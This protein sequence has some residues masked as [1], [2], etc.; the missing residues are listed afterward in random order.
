MVLPLPSHDDSSRFDFFEGVRSFNYRKIVSPLVEDY[1]RR[2]TAV[3]GAT[4]RTKEQAG[5]FYTNDPAYLFA[6]ALQRSMQQMAWATAVESVDR[7]AEAVRSALKSTLHSSEFSRLE[8][9][10][11]AEL[12]AWYTWHTREGLDDIHLVPGG[13][14]HH[15]LIGAVYDRGGAVYRLAWR[16]G[17]DARPG[18]LEA[19][20]R[21][22]PR[23]D[24]A[25]VLDLGCSFGGLTRVL[26]TVFT[27]A[28]VVGIDISAPALTYAHH[29]AETNGQAIV[30]SQ[31]DA[32]A[33]GYDDDSFDLVTA[34]LLLH[35]V[36]DEVRAEILAE[37]F[38]ILR[39]G[40][41]LMFLDIPPYSALSPVEAFFESFDGR[42]NGENFWEEFL[43]EDFP[44]ALAAAGFTEIADGPLDFAEDA[45]W[46]SS[47]L[48][49][50]GEFNEVHRWV[51]HA[52][53]PGTEV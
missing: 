15:E 31:R 28:E 2:I 29:V 3:A 23:T 12:P 32:I 48:W 16:G 14:W 50:T 49:R 11:D 27:E 18:A 22:A 37:A 8:L 41:H 26:R 44:R 9:V 25:R 45:Y 47:A 21:T 30:Y 53:K 19:F 43:S 4:P 33:T 36:P 46:G 6:C 40:G 24:C 1:P 10:P 34:F 13:Y 42:G 38:R 20:V 51:T 5:T 17:Y 39:P 52:T 35:E 7:D